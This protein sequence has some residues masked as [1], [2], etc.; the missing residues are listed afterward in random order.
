M[1]RQIL[2][3]RYKYFSEVQW[4][5]N[6]TWSSCW[7]DRGRARGH[8]VPGEVTLTTEDWSSSIVES[9]IFQWLSLIKSLTMR[10]WQNRG[11][12]RA[13]APVSR[14]PAQ[15]REEEARVGGE[16]ETE[17]LSMDFSFQKRSRWCEIWWF[18][19]WCLK[20]ILS[21]FK[22]FKTMFFSTKNFFPIFFQ[23]FPPFEFFPKF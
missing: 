6:Q 18:S 13:R 4:W 23:F 21:H 11:E 15:G 9:F 19:L 20:C 3:T 10:C 22:P 16:A 14:G 17:A 8:S 2:F 1:R 5:A 7:G 12:L